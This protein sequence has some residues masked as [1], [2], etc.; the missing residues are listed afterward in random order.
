MKKNIKLVLVAIATLIAG[1]VWGGDVVLPAGTYYFDLTN[2]E[3]RQIDVFND[4]NNAKHNDNTSISMQ[5]SDLSFDSSNPLNSGV[6]QTN[7]KTFYKNSGLTYFVVSLAYD[8]KIGDNYNFLQYKNMSD[9]DQGWHAYSQ[10]NLTN[11]GTL[12]N[13]QYVCIVYSDRYEWKSTG[14]V[15]SSNPTL[16]YTAG[17]HGRISTHKAGGV[18]FDSNP[19]SHASGTSINLVAVADANYSFYGWSKPD[20]TIVSMDEDYTFSM[21]STNLSLTAVFYKDSTDPAISGCEG[22]FRVAP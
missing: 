14:S 4:L 22:C 17:E 9:Q 11:L 18:N 12:D 16:T 6:T 1:N 13:K 7:S 2:V 15:P 3:A 21:P 8:M 19:S 20:G 10:T 5:W